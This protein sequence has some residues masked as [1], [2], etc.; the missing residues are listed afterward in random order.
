MHDYLCA[1]RIRVRP[2][3]LYNLLKRE[4]ISRNELARR[5][6]VSNATA[7]RIDEGMVEP[8]PKFIAALISVSGEKFED[9]FEIV[10]EDAA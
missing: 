4:G 10:T 5:M 2:G 1:M 9:L 6:G 3:V 7:Y 8:S